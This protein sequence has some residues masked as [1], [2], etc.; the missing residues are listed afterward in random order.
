MNSKAS[1]APA[2]LTIFYGG[3]VNVFDDISPEKVHL[4]LCLSLAIFFFFRLIC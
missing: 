3:A 1:P 2:Q 4:F